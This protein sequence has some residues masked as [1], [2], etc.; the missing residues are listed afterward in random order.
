MAAVEAAVAPPPPPAATTVTTTEPTTEPTTTATTTTTVSYS[1]YRTMRQEI[2][3]PITFNSYRRYVSNGN[4]DGPGF[5]G[6][7][8]REQV[9]GG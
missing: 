1:Q 2:P 3:G 6:R 5:L 8:W 7:Y 4:E 9:H